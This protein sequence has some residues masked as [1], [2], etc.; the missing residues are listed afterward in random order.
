[1]SSSL[2]R[3]TPQPPRLVVAALLAL[4]A[5]AAVVLV[6]PSARLQ[7]VGRHAGRAGPG[8]RARRERHRGGRLRPGAQ[9]AGG[10]TRARG[11]SIGSLADRPRPEAD[12]RRDADRFPL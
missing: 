5:T 1:M 9:P 10:P 3:S 12:A 2:T 8:E 4:A 7:R 11:G 6:W